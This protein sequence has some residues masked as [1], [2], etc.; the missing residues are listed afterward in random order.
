M[1]SAPRRRRVRRVLGRQLRPVGATVAN[2]APWV[3]T[4]SAGT[5]DRDFPAYVTLP[6]GARLA[7]VSLY[8]G[9]SPSPRPA[10]LPLV[11]GG[12]GER[13]QALPARNA[14]PG[15]RAR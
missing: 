8:A 9:P 2:S 4:V 7:G 15:R 11:Y 3:A 10:M 12:G 6:T 14:R 13:Q 5:L 1:R